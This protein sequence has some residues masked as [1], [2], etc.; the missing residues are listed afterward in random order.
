M[1]ACFQTSAIMNR[2]NTI[3]AIRCSIPLPGVEVVTVC[4]DDG[5]FETFFH[6]GRLDGER[7]AGIEQDSNAQ[8]ERACR[9]ARLAGCR[10]DAV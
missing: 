10:K 2:M 4:A 1:A 3:E 6:G 8:H 7:F 5:K 9:L